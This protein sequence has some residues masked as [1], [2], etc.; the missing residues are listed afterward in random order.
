MLAPGAPQAALGQSVRCES[1]WAAG[2]QLARHCQI[3]PVLPSLRSRVQVRLL[4]MRTASGVQ[5]EPGTTKTTNSRVRLG[6][7]TEPSLADAVRRPHRT[8]QVDGSG[9]LTRATRC[10]GQDHD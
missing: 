9:L 7:L 4:R 2:A 10:R 1:I 3:W 5:N 6:L 8:P